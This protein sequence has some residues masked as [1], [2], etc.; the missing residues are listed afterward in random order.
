MIFYSS[1]FDLIICMNH[2]YA[3]CRENIWIFYFDFS[4]LEFVYTNLV[5]SKVADFFS[6]KE[7]SKFED[8][9]NVYLISRIAIN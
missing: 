2:L 6:E 1:S 3:D 9:E 5:S 4:N 7:V 8:N